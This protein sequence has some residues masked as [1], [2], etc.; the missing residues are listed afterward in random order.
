MISKVTLN[1]NGYA[2][3]NNCQNKKQNIAFSGLTDRMGKK[4]Y[5]GFYDMAVLFPR[6]TTRN[7]IS[8][9]IPDFML[10]KIKLVT[11]DIESASKEIY[12]V[13]SEVSNELRDFEPQANSKREEFVN[14]RSNTTVKK[15]ENVLEKYKIISKWDD[16]DLVYLGKGG[17]GSVWKLEGL[18][19]IEGDI[20]D[21]FV[22]KVF[23]SKSIQTNAYH[24]CYPEINSAT[25]WMNTFGH[26]TNRGKFFWGD[27]HEA[28]MI[29][30][31]ID[32]DVRLPKKF[33]NP[34]DYG[35]KFTDEN[36]EIL[37]NICKRFSYDWGGGV[38]INQVVNSSKIARHVM[39]TVQNEPDKYKLQ[40]W[41]RLFNMNGLSNQDNKVAGLVLAIKYLDPGQRVKCFEDCFLKRGK[42]TD[43]ALGYT[44]KYLPY[45]KAVK[46]YEILAKSTNDNVLKGILKNEIPLLSKRDEFAAGMKDDLIILDQF[47]DSYLEKYVD[48][49][50][51]NEY[52]KL[53]DKYRLKNVTLY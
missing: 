44:L 53:A 32:E 49:N 35:I 30:K 8:G 1:N 41:H 36:A 38:V 50:K 26:D 28:Y 46:Y 40:T 34:Y 4:I 25:Y 52:N 19:H 15:L 7:S 23:H 18:R 10:K 21:E 51:F 12:K 27:V 33:P 48:T 22:I 14:K 2:T 9:K 29:N 20:E 45:E 11:N 13:F 17:K 5:N 37:H 42:Y 3:N 24:G 31:Y 47:T 39:H 6:E 43:R 16:F